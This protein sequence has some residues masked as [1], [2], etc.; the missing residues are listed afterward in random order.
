MVKCLDCNL[1]MTAHTLKYI[2]KKGGYC[3]GATQDSK[4]EEEI[5]TV[6]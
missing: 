3:K 4:T 1:S 2:H 6:K 5:K